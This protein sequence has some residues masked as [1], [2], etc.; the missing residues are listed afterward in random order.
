LG[1][2]GRPAGVSATMRA[3]VIARAGGPE[4]LEIREVARPEPAS[5]EVRVRVRAFGI[6]RADLLQRRG[7]YPAPPDAP[8][9]IPGLE[10]AGE[11]DALGE[12]VS[13]VARGDRVMGIVGGGSYAEYLCTPASHLLRIPG[14]MSFN[15]AAAIPE[16]F[17]TAHDAL[18]Q[19]E[20]QAGEWVLVHAVGSG[21]GSAA[22]QLVH[23]RGAK[24]IGTSRTRDKLERALA[25]GLDVAVE[26]GKEDLVAAVRAAT[27]RGVNA[28]VDLIGGSAFSDTLR[29][30]A[31]RGRLIVVGLTAGARA[32]VD[33]GV[34]LR[35]RLHIVGTVLRARSKDEKAALTQSFAPLVSLFEKG[36]LSPV[37]DR[38][39]ALEQVRVA[40]V[41]MESN[42][43][44]G[45]V[46]VEVS[47]GES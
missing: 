32:E 42:A 20:V 46:V 3:V 12:R 9:D 31:P 11:V 6:N 7:L 43:N 33:L 24:C 8:Q 21:V 35:N 1:T 15:D 22:L 29:C 5:G 37:V 4:V 38:V 47:S 13:G 34:V 18:E 28:V 36:A 44:F 23:A 10:F 19:L 17:L 27:G 40:H 30:M 16:A 39:F 26:T 41:C 25:R 2:F 14:R 45:K